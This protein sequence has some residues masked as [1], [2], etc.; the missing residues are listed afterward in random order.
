MTLP[1]SDAWTNASNTSDTSGNDHSALA[2][3]YH[4]HA[5]IYDAT[6]WSFLF[7]RTALIHALASTPH[8]PRNI[9]EIGCGTGDNLLRLA[10]QFPEAAITGLDLS[11]DMLRR[12][13]RKVETHRLPITLLQ[14]HYDRPLY[15]KPIFDL[16]VFSY[17]LSMI[18]PGWNL[19]LESAVQDLRPGGR[20]AVVD[21][22]DTRFAG[23]RRWMGI[24]HVRMDGHLLSFLS[25]ISQ[26][27]TTTL[28]KAYGGGWRYFHFI[29][30]K[31]DG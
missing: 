5:R 14:Q 15:P 20:L 26:P 2:R 6:R 12:A 13:R 9:L 25:T 22:H 19:A 16:I 10:R 30:Q 24:H 29:G 4:W 27:M 3:Y 23:F 1:N 21:F 8:P 11:I 18:N 31:L 28:H 7:G 17:C